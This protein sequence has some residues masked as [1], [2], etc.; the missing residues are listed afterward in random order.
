MA[1]E[2]L[3]RTQ[4]VWRAAYYRCVMSKGCQIPRPQAIIIVVYMSRRSG[5]PF[6]EVRWKVDRDGGASSREFET[7]IR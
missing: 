3:K 1:I 6:K 5:S 2:D 4:F 7:K